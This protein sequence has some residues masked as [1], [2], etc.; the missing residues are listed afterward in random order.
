MIEAVLYISSFACSVAAE[1]VTCSLLVIYA[2][3]PA[4]ANFQIFLVDKD[5]GRKCLLTYSVLFSHLC[6]VSHIWITDSVT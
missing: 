6:L 1:W 3:L 4:V 5:N 2:P